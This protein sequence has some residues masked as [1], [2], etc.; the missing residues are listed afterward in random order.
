MLDRPSGDLGADLREASP[1]PVAFSCGG[2]GPARA[3]G[4]AQGCE[5]SGCRHQVGIPATNAAMTGR[6]HRGACRLPRQACRRGILRLDH[7]ARR[8]LPGIAKSLATILARQG[9]KSEQLPQVTE[10]ARSACLSL[11][12]GPRQ[13]VRI[14]HWTIISTASDLVSA[15]VLLSRQSSDARVP[16]WRRAVCMTRVGTQ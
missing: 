4:A 10:C 16:L 8:R 15:W 7:V 1:G 11:C 9:S 2:S 13:S 3:S 14:N 12:S 5:I 6:H